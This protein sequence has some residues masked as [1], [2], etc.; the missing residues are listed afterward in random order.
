MNN[1]S[2][3]LRLKQLR[4]LLQLEKEEDK[5]LYETQ[6]TT[7]TIEQKVLKGICWYPIEI[8]EWGYGIGDYPFLIVQRH[9]KKEIRHQFEGG[10]P[11]TLFSG[12]SQHKN[13]KINGTIHFVTPDTM[14]IIFYLNDLPDWIDEGKVGVEMHFD[15]SSYREMEKALAEFEK[16]TNN[17]VAH[18]RE[19]LYGNKSTESFNEI[20]YTFNP[21]LN[22]SQN[23]AIKSILQSKDVA[24][25]HG[26]PGTGKTTTLVY[27]IKEL[28][29][30][31]QQVLVCAPSNSAADLLTESLAKQG[32]YVLRIGNL[33]RIDYDVLQHTVEEKLCKHSHYKR[34]KEYKKQAEEYRRLAHKYKRNF[35]PE[36]REQRKLLLK[37]AKNLA[38]EA[39]EL[40]NSL[41][42]E[43]IDHAQAIVCTLVGSAHKFLEGKLFK[44][45]LIDEAAQALEPACLIPLLKAQKL[46]MA[47]DPCQLPATIKSLK[48][49]QNGLSVSLMERL[50]DYIPHTTLLDEQYRMNNI[51]MN[52]SNNYFY[53][54]KL[55]SNKKNAQI[56]LNSSLQSPIEFIDTAGCGYNEELNPETSSLYKVNSSHKCNFIMVS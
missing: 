37:E 2:S 42:Y 55:T 39:V 49:A 53:N 12:N 47:G 34:V 30:T 48:A 54:G 3:L 20:N 36:E 31:E 24:I 17:R 9:Q 41:I 13:E 25:I 50:L 14:K 22:L 10:K 56:L 6:L 23:R 18:L 27:A 21:Y 40:E 19:I 44:T 45:V 33:S 1:N 29:K 38:N 52:F 7:L 8:K 5:K 11:V 46:V 4:E 26:P 43:L 28:I 35:G 51:I 32:I 16:A 15:E